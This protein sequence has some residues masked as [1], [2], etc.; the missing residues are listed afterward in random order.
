MLQELGTEW[1]QPPA[2]LVNAGSVLEGLQVMTVMTVMTTAIC[3]KP[4]L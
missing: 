1:S 3:L 2:Q 4:R